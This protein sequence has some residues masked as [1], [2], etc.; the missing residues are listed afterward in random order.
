MVL[1]SAKA[2]VPNGFSAWE[3]LAFY[4]GLGLQLTDLEESARPGSHTGPESLK[5]PPIPASMLQALPDDLSAASPD[6]QARLSDVF[7]SRPVVVRRLMQNEI[8]MGGV[9]G[10]TADNLGKTY[11][12]SQVG[13]FTDLITDKSVINMEFTEYTKVMQNES[14]AL[15]ARAIKDSHQVMSNNVPQDWLASIANL[16]WAQELSRFIKKRD[17]CCVLFVGSNHTFTNGH[18]DIGSSVFMMVQGRKRWIFFPPEDTPYLYPMPQAKNVAFNVGVDIFHPNFEQT[19]LFANARGYEVV[20][21][22]GD[23]LFFPSMWWHAIQNLDSVTV[24]IDYPI[25]DVWGSWK[26]HSVLAA[27]TLLN[28]KLIASMGMTM[29]QGKSIRDV[30]FAGYYKSP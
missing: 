9:L 10:L 30:F 13:V 11:K 17:G 14:K 20:L 1:A 19:P 24:G 8:Q 28:P 26:R 15:Y 23:V 2:P 21:E 6:W 5:Q 12:G 4:S 18:C 3:T 29:L 22:P 7:P 16:E 25:W 27:A